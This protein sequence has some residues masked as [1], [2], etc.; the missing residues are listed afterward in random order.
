MLSTRLRLIWEEIP[1][2]ETLK[3]LITEIEINGSYLSS[4]DD[5]LIDVRCSLRSHQRQP[6][7][8]R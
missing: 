1:N 4:I 8:D 6:F 5:R 2:N 3:D 7:K